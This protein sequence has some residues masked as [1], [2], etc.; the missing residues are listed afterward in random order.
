MNRNMRLNLFALGSLMLTQFAASPA[1]GATRQEAE[2]LIRD[3][4]YPKAVSV[5]RT[6]MMN[7]GNQRNAQMNKWFG[8]ALCMTGAYEES[9]PYLEKGAKGNQLGALWYLGISRQHLYDFEGAIDV[10]EKY[11]AKCSPTSGWRE[12]TD[13]IIAE[14]TLG[15]RA[16]NRVEDVTV[17]DSL[18]VPRAEFFAHYMLGSE[19][20]RLLSATELGGAYAAMAD[21]DGVV[22]ENQ[23]ADQRLFCFENT[24]YQSRC[25]QGKW[26]E[27]EPVPSVSSEAFRITMPFMRSDGSTLYFA[28]DS[29]PGIGGLDIYMTRYDR[30]E[31]RFLAPQ[32]L[33]MPFN[34]PFDDYMMAIDETHRVGW[35]ATE[36]N[37]TADFVCIY[38]F[39]FNEEPVYLE[40]PQPERARIAAVTPNDSLSAAL[41]EAPQEVVAVVPTIRI[42]IN[43]HTVYTS[44]DQFRSAGARQ[45]YLSSLGLA[46]ALAEVE[47]DLDTLRQQYHQG[48]VS[49]RESLRAQIMRLEERQESL[50]RMLRAEEKRYRTLENK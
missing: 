30:D 29:T 24:L 39:Q 22:F 40:G 46:E 17:F 4:N 43:D 2:S 28:S 18:L 49:Q 25:F 20:G 13:S 8:E 37:A 3:K 27:P 48:N 32:R 34:S 50:A 35:F 33:G 42:P 5:L 15:L 44:A 10:L 38:L 6:L 45:A 41:M 21:R 11:K 9:L 16:L 26:E 12:R 7:A 31:G 23:P 14:C 47:S 1:W 36:R 19:S